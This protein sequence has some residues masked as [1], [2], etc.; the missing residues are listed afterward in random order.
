[1][2]LG[3]DAKRFF[4]NKTGLGNYSRDLIRI[5]AQYHPENSYLLYNP[6][7][8][9]IDRIPI[10]GKIVIEHLPDSKKDKK[11][12]SLWRLFSICSQINKDK[13]KITFYLFLNRVNVQ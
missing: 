5:L 6:K 7:P 13:V 11:L 10:D 1:M 9:K 12:S 4:H 2:I 3:F 8:K